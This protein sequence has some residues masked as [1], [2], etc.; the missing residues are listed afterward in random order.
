[1]PGPEHAWLVGPHGRHLTELVVPI[2]LKASGPVAGDGGGPPP[3]AT[4][5]R[6][7]AVP[8]TGDRLRPPG[9]DWLFVKLYCP[10]NVEEELLTGPVRGFCQ[11]ATGGGLAEQWFFLR[12]ADPEPHLR[13]RF[14]G[15]PN[16]LVTD[17]FPK[18]CS[19]SSDLIA[20]GLCRR[21]GFDTYER[22]IERYGGLAAIG[23]AEAL[24]AADSAAVV[25]LLRLG[26]T[27]LTTID[28]TAVAVLSVD[29]LLDGLGFD[30]AKRLDWYR[31]QVSAKHLS[32]DD[33]R[34]RQRALRLLLGDRA[35]LRSEPGGEGLERILAARS[36]ALASVGE[37][38]RELGMTHQLDVPLERLCESYVHLHCNRLL[39]VGSPTEQHVLGLLLRTLEGLER[40]PV[41]PREP[42]T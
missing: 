26:Q 20:E 17:L 8:G 27:E 39:G 29:A 11:F 9:S 18:I 32:G 25:E 10:R 21:I 5:R 15:D 1:L 34:A 3:P 24:F 42:A 30:P 38:L 36:A 23:P 16:R 7:R 13:V 12:Y 41:A 2:A 31:G 28:R 40:A 6:P 4:E 33:Y 19:W 35:G 22:E 14:G 37:R